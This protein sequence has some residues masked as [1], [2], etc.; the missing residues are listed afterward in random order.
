MSESTL[1]SLFPAAT[2]VKS[3]CPHTQSEF[4]LVKRIDWWDRVTTV[5]YCS[6]CGNKLATNGWATGEGRIHGLGRYV[7][8]KQYRWA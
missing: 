2:E 3:A 1:D 4:Q 5:A 6:E 8:M 7:D